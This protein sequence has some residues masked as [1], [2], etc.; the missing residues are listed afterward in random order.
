MTFKKILAIWLVITALS[1]GA[2]YFLKMMFKTHPLW[3]WAVP[4]LYI[5]V[6]ILF[7]LYLLAAKED[8][9]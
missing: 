4:I 6:L 5:G 3:G 9:K 8:K 2:F 1:G 7:V